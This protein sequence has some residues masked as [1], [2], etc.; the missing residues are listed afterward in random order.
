VPK[1]INRVITDQLSD[2]LFTP[3]SDADDNLLAE[4]TD[5]ST[6]HVLTP[7]KSQNGGCTR[8]AALVEF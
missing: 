5:A 1:E 2:L 7:P 8:L 3:S 6:I 4:G